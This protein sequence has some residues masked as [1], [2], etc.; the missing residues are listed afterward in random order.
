MLGFL[1]DP[2]EC[3]GLLI[4]THTFLFQLPCFALATH[5]RPNKTTQ[6][7]TCASSRLSHLCAVQ[8]CAVNA[9]CFLST[10]M[11]PGRPDYGMALRLVILLSPC[12]QT[13]SNLYFRLPLYYIGID[14]S[15]PCDMLFLVK[16][17]ISPAAMLGYVDV[18][19]TCKATCCP[20]RLFFRVREALCLQIV[21]GEYDS[22]KASPSFATFG[23][24]TFKPRPI[25]ISLNLRFVLLVP[26]LGCVAST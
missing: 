1:R 21:L 5:D 18:Y 20:A 6:L 17:F 4:S 16:I 8:C 12:S 22:G 2:D 19:Y 14:L 11:R 13:E 7:L 24:G 23:P 25:I 15:V 26:L 9:R 10:E 3:N